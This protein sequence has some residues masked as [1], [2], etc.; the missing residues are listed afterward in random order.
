MTGGNGGVVIVIQTHGMH[1]ACNSIELDPENMINAEYSI[2]QLSRYLL[3][4]LML[5][6]FAVQRI[7]MISS[8][9][10]VVVI[11]KILI[12]KLNLQENNN[13]KIR[14]DKPLVVAFVVHAT[15]EFFKFLA[16]AAA[17]VAGEQNDL[18]VNI[19]GLSLTLL[20]CRASY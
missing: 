14:L 7:E 4:G 13:G 16:A 2:D 5:S 11:R 18:I 8:T 9:D 15:N 20:Q 17:A 3:S 19:I 6:H 1:M 12:Q 10:D